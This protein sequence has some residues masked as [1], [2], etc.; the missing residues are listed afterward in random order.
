MGAGEIS[1]VERP[2]LGNDIYQ[3]P[4]RPQQVVTDPKDGLPRVASTVSMEDSKAPPLEPE[5]FVCMGDESVFV[6]RDLWG[7]VRLRFDPT[8]VRRSEDEYFVRRDSLSAERLESLSVVE[9]EL[10]DIGALSGKTDLLLK[11]HALR[12]QCHHYRRVMTDFE[13]HDVHRTVERVC[14]AQR[15]EGGEYVALGNTR[16]YAC[17]HRS[18]RDFVS[19]DRLRKFDAERVAEGKKSDEEWDGDAALDAALRTNGETTDGC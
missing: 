12:P 5:S 14:S 4:L 16:I 18:P 17:E 3:H 19:E 11:V 15:T 2:K 13:G 6:V 10:Y 1:D 9:R 8:E 7:E